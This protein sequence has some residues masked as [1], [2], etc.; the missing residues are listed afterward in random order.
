VR[1][2]PIPPRMAHLPKDRRGL[3]IPVI[4]LWTAD[5]RP[6]FA[7]NDE[8]E[9][10][11]MIRE[12]RCHVCGGQLLRGRWFVGGPLSVCAEHGLN[13][14]GGMHDECA[15][16]ALKVCPYLAAPVY[17]GLVG[18]KQIAANRAEV[19][20]VET[21]TEMNS[22]PEL[23]VAVMAVGQEEREGGTLLPGVAEMRMVYGVRPKPGSV[24]KAELWKHGNR[25]MPTPMLLAEIGLAID[26]AADRWR[27][28]VFVALG[29]T[30]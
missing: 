26:A 1:A 6:I 18:A 17:S 21:G 13:L 23:F 14:D 20:V 28:D 22:R 7:A 4:V 15:H 3:P 24:R 19:I 27:K 8:G 16:Y 29:G 2:V 25:Y 30:P 11:K 5:G 10:Q 9:R 12:D